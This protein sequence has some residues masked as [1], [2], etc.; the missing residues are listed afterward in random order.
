MSL[1][2]D[3]DFEIVRTGY[4]RTLEFIENHG[5]DR[6]FGLPHGK[7]LTGYMKKLLTNVVNG[8][9]ALPIYDTKSN[10]NLCNLTPKIPSIQS[11]INRE[12]FASKCVQVS[13]HQICVSTLIK[14]ENRLCSE[15]TSGREKCGNSLSFPKK[16][17]EIEKC[18]DE[19]QTGRYSVN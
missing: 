12:P 16:H 11:H 5:G 19:T 6:A 14:S 9:S 15:K 10:S 13:R 4:E 3:R 2:A 7:K 18:N 17:K 1:R 8:I